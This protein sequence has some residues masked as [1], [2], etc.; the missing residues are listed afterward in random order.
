MNKLG[1]FTTAGKW[2]Y[3]AAVQN[4][5]SVPP[6]P[7]EEHHEAIGKLNNII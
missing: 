2:I 4:I 7:L 6:F 3:T 1:A 5:Y